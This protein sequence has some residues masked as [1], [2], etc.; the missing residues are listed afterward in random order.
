M[1]KILVVEDEET[2]KEL[3]VMNLEMEGY[4]VDAAE[5]GEIAM[6]K[7]QENQYDLVVL[8]VMMP[9]M[10]GFELCEKWRA[11]GI[12]TPILFLSARSSGEDRVK[13]LRLGGDDYLTKPFELDELLLRV[14]K[15]LPSVPHEPKRELRIGE[16]RVNEITY[17]VTH[18]DNPSFELS[19]REMKLLKLMDSKRGE[20][21][22]RDTILDEIWGEQAFPTPRTVDNYFLNF[23]KYFELDSK[24][25]KY[26]ISIRGVGYKLL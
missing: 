21:V 15:R 20:V 8:D 16:Y 6:M 2:L 25:P 10:D 14:A 22:S 5:D 19:Q 18:P 11:Q 3:V 12:K 17:E 23:R 13:G 1:A 24:N 9:K 26:F 4:F 7:M